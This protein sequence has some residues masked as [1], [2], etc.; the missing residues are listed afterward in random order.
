MEFRK[1]NEASSPSATPIAAPS[2]PSKGGRLGTLKTARCLGR[3]D[4][5]VPHSQAKEA[6]GQLLGGSVPR[7]RFLHPPEKAG[8]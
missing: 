3:E 7:G 1:V 6:L 8:I 4:T 2:L 5:Q